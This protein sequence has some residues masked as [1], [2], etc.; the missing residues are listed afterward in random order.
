[1]EHAIND[2][3]M[4]LHQSKTSISKTHRFSTAINK[5]KGCCASGDTGC[6]IM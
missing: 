3:D 1:M 5:Q 4:A 2:G 6:V